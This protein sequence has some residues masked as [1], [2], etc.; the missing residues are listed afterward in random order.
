MCRTDHTIE[1][2]AQAYEL[3]L[4]DGAMMRERKLRFDAGAGVYQ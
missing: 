1:E 3:G 2:L 4:R